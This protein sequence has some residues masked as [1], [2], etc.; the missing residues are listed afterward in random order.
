MWQAGQFT[1]VELANPDVSGPNADPDG[2]GWSN[3]FEFALGSLPLDVSSAPGGLQSGLQEIDGEWYLTLSFTRAAGERAVD[4]SAE[5]SVDLA[6]WNGGALP[7]L[8]SLVHSDGSVTATFRHPMPVAG[9]EHY[10]RLKATG[11]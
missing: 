8:P 1:P 2:D 7:V 10:L 9:G 3:F 4:F 5:I 11:H 6:S